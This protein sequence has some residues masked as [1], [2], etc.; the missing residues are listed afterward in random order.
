MENP[1]ALIGANPIAA[2]A[3]SF[4]AGILFAVIVG[5]MLARKSPPPA[6]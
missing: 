6:S 3:I 2:V 4:A 5:R 1:K